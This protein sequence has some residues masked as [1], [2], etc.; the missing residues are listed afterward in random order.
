ML[1]RRE[2]PRLAGMMRELIIKGS[3]MR[4]AVVGHVE[5]AEFVRVER[6]PRA[7]EIVHAME[8]WEGVGGGGA[9]AA[10]ELARLAGEAL[11]VTALGDDAIGH[12][13]VSELGAHG[14]RVAAVFRAEPQRRVFVHV[15]G[16]GERTITVIGARIAPQRADDLPWDELAACDAVYFTAGDA[17]AVRAARAAR[18]LVATPRALAAL[19]ES[20]V[21][22]DALVG[23]ARDVGERVRAG[24]LDP[25]PDLLVQTEGADGGRY[26]RPSGAIGRFRAAPLAGPA[27]DTYGA[28]DSF[29]AGLTHALGARRALDDA[30]A[31]AALCGAGALARRGPV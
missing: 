26:V 16:A 22:L 14:V 2:D 25:P 8:R 19:V 31:L 1:L 6:L 29:A 11:F 28:G 27:V 17:G 12:R 21:R 23:S 4:V 30:L 10:V 5:W 7:G 9:V 18:V 3:A 13:T 20:R 15:D 24:D